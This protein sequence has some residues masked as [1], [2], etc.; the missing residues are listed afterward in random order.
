MEKKQYIQ[1]YKCV[2]YKKNT[3]LNTEYVYDTS[4]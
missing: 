4:I 2:K 3:S 1:N